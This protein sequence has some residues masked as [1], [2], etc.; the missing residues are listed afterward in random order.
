ME[1]HHIELQLKR[2]LK[3]STGL[4]GHPS[5]HLLRFFLS[6]FCHPGTDSF[7]ATFQDAHCSAVGGLSQ[8]WALRGQKRDFIIQ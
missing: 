6:S 4:L 1:Q 8:G 3:A 7:G 5:T 2:R